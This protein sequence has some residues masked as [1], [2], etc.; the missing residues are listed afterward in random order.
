MMWHLYIIIFVYI[1]LENIG[2]GSTTH[3][4]RI[5]HI[6]RF[7]FYFTSISTLAFWNIPFNS[8]DDDIWQIGPINGHFYAYFDMHI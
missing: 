4:W 2:K 6:S 7:D 5:G 8:K 3:P 1:N